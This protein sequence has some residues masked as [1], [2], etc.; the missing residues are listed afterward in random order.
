MVPL[1]NDLFAHALWFAEIRLGERPPC[2]RDLFRA[3]TPESTGRRQ[4]Q[5]QLQEQTSDA[6]E[7]S[8]V[9]DDGNF[10]NVDLV[11]T[12]T[13]NSESGDDI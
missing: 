1:V 12:H 9:D 13:D 3:A 7:G 10:G 11:A 4:L 5:L 2:C 8:D 6:A